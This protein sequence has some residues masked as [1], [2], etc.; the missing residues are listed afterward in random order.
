MAGTQESTEQ[1]SEGGDEL[2]AP[3][4]AQLALEHIAQLTA[5]KVVGVTSVE[6]TD[7]GWQVGVE[8]VEE[9]R[10]PSSSDLL[11]IYQ[12][13]LDLDGE[14]LSYRRTQRYHRGRGNGGNGGS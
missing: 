4:A 2:T 8:V 3:E 5:K 12:A 6:P 1:S 11:A 14:L 7:D 13:D 10:V 9:S